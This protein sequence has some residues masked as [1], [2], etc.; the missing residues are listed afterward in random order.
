[1]RKSFLFLLQFVNVNLAALVVSAA[2]VTAGAVLT[3]VPQG[4]DN[5]FTSYFGGFPVALML[6]SYIFGFA[7]FSTNLNMGLSFGARRRDF[8]WAVQGIFGLYTG[9]SC[10]L[11][12]VMARIPGA[13]GWQGFDQ[14]WY[15]ML[16]S[17]GWLFPILCMSLLA[18]GAL[19]GLVYVRSRA[20]GA[21][22]M[23]AGSM[24]VVLVMILMML[25]GSLP[26]W[27]QLPAVLAAG[28]A[29]LFLAAEA[30]L[31]QSVQRFVVR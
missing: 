21:V 26:L 4:A 29:V 5:L 24:A 30:V 31:W 20:W 10:L 1:M 22:L 23:G 11:W 3:G 2:V 14:R 25:S 17:P 28:C 8:F 9:V 7:L 16:Y 15:A 18:L 27:E 19:T 12:L 13:M 6:L